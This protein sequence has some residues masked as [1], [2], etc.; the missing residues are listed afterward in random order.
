MTLL[1]TIRQT[2]ES[3]S[4][5]KEENRARLKSD[6]KD[7]QN[8]RAKLE[9]SIDPLDPTDHPDEIVNI[10]S[11]RKAPSAVTVDNAVEMGKV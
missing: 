5:H 2:T 6:R 8:I 1:A 3:I 11:G 4:S 7:R 10:V 9:M